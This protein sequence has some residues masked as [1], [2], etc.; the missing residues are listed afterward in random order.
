MHFLLL[1]HLPPPSEIKTTMEINGSQSPCNSKSFCLEM[2]WFKGSMLFAVDFIKENITIFR[3]CIGLSFPST[4]ME[5]SW[6]FI[7][8]NHYCWLVWPGHEGS[9]PGSLWDR[10]LSLLQFGSKQNWLPHHFLGSISAGPETTIPGL[11]K[12]GYWP[13]LSQLQATGLLYT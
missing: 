7:S 4:G 13:H 5:N 12:P 9:E 10:G 3:H 6:L 1:F 11:S 2:W 8:R